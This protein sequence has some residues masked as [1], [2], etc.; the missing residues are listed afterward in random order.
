[1]MAGLVTR[2]ARLA[3]RRQQQRVDRIARELRAMFGDAAVEVEEARL[4]VRGKELIKRWL[5]D[6]HLRFLGGLSR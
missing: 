4:L 2:G 5:I 1:M 3:A 6:P